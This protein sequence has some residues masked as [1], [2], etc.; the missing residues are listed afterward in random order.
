LIISCTF[1]REDLH[2]H[3]ITLKLV[4]HALKLKNGHDM[5]CAVTTWHATSRKETTCWRES[6]PFM[7]F[8]LGLMNQSSNIN[9]QNGNMRDCHKFHQNPSP[10]KLMVIVAYD[11]SV[12]IV[13]PFVPHGRTMA[14]DYYRSF[15]QRQLR[16][17]VR[18]KSSEQCHHSP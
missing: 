7:N 18:E 5:Q 4:P 11:I 10:V 15:L 16:H 13:C 12:V 6:S 3:K 8:G 17:A 1:L 2:L 9:Q 14:A